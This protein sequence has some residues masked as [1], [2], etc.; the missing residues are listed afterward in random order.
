MKMAKKFFE[1]KEI[2]SGIIINDIPTKNVDEFTNSPFSLSGNREEAR[3]GKK[4]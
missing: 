4:F 3:N 2:D 1:A